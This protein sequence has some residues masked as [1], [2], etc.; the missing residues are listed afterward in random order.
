MVTMLVPFDK[1]LVGW[2]K[3]PQTKLLS[4][5]NQSRDLNVKA[6]LG[7]IK[8]TLL[9]EPCDQQLDVLSEAR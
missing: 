7:L 4:K 3:T 1:L 6:K 9:F 8:F 2:C 5:L